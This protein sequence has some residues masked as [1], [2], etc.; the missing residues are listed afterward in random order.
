MPIIFVGCLDS[1]RRMGEDMILPSQEMTTRVDETG[2][3]PRTYYYAVKSIETNRTL[4]GDKV[5]GSFID[6]L[7]GR[8]TSQAFTNYTPFGFKY[9][10]T[11]YFGNEPT[12]DSMKI[13]LLFNDYRGDT[14]KGTEVEVYEVLK[15]TYD[16][17]SRFNSDYEMAPNLAG[18]PLVRFT[19]KSPTQIVRKLPREFMD[20]FLINTQ[21]KT[22]PYYYDTVFHKFFKGL[23]FKTKTVQKGEGEGCIYNLNL[24]GSKMELYYHNKNEKPDTTY[25]SFIMYSTQLAPNNT[26]FETVQQDYTFADPAVGGVDVKEIGNSTLSTK[27]CYVSAPAGLST[28]MVFPQSQID[29][30]K[31]EAQKLGY[32]DIAVQAAELTLFVHNPVWENY[33]L[34]FLNVS[35]YKDLPKFEF[36][37]DYQP[38]TGGNTLGG[39]LVRSIG[40]YKLNISSYLQGRF[41]G[42]IKYEELE[43]APAMTYYLRPN[44]SVFYG[45][46]SAQPP[47]LKLTYTLLK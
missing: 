12:L 7:T 17:K 38:A 18:E 26:N 46:S 28:K 37:P 11:T 8:L 32:K 5:V 16:Y 45:S 10:S 41:T 9:G 19:L 23:Y 44:R 14:T 36:M 47:K 3:V 21:D 25:I 27:L 29:A 20:K 39:S 13:T 2:I 42:K 24:S 6:P 22:N 35:A 31:E 4:F 1:D 30:I 33:N 34:M 15:G 40:V 43:I